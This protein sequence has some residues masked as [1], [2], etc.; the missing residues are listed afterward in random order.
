MNYGYSRPG[1]FSANVFYLVVGLLLLFVGFLVQRYE[2]YLGL[3]VTEY[4]L[5]LIPSIIF[6]KLRG[7]SLKRVLRLNGFT[8]KQLV[9]TILMV[10]FSY[11]IAVFLNLIV[12]NIINLF[13][14]FM[15]TTVPIPVTPREFLIS[16]IVIA[17]TPGICEEV[18]F[19]GPILSAYESL[20]YKKAII[21]SALLFGIFHFNITNLVGPTFL[22]MVLGVV[23]LKSNT[24]FLPMIGH[25]LNNTIA[26]SI[27]Y[28]ATKYSPEL[29]DLDGTLENGA[30]S[31]TMAM[32]V[33]TITIGLIALLCGFILYKLIKKFPSRYRQ[34]EMNSAPASSSLSYIPVAVVVVI[35]VV[36]SW[37]TL[38]YV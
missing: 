16:F 14:E 35:F 29:E 3:L 28:F 27:G 22:G 10:L 15:P 23:A 1:I 13:T 24:I 8:F 9:Y 17:V 32:I 33:S 20:G 18:M 19:R 25:T 5:I 30:L 38:T 11:P 37:L 21:I 31:E 4:I 36:L 12:M 2:L 6:I 26:L 7:L 34:V